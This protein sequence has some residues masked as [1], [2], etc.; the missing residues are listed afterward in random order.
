MKILR[1][2]FLFTAIP[3]FSLAQIEVSGYSK[4][5]TCEMGFTGELP[6]PVVTSP[7]G[8]VKTTISEDIFS[9]GCAGTL[10]RTFT[11]SDNCGDTTTVQQFIRLTDSE[12]P[13]LLGIPDNV[14]LTDQ[15][16]P[17]PPQVMAID[18]SKKM[19]TVKF[20]EEKGERVITRRW[21]AT[22]DCDNTAT[23]EQKIYLAPSPD[24]KK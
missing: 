23:A 22:D 15:V 13:V 17:A 3:S 5:I 18:N 11:Y 20:S 12:E 14:Q 8:K 16:V 24:A 9:G 6:F 2:L 19:L 1:A 7:C 10:V 21:S 4:E